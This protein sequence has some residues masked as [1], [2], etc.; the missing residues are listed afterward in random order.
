MFNKNLYLIAFHSLLKGLCA[1]YKLVRKNIKTRV[2]VSQRV[3]TA[4]PFDLCQ[5][6]SDKGQ[7]VNWLEEYLIPL[8][9]MWWKAWG[10]AGDTKLAGKNDIDSSSRQQEVEEDGTV[11][12]WSALEKKN[13]DNY[14]SSTITTMLIFLVLCKYFPINVAHACESYQWH[15]IKSACP[16]WEGS[17]E[18]GTNG[19]EMSYWHPSYNFTANKLLWNV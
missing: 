9:G 6:R 10:K 13:C 14:F 18:S 4:Q 3:C 11:W 12:S 16:L 8:L 17:V 5:N 7:K 1:Q 19:K 15:F 2:V